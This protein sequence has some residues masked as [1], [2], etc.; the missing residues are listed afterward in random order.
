MAGKVEVTMAPTSFVVAAGDTAEA[1][2]T[3][4]NQG[5]TVDQLTISIDGLDPGWYSIPV[6][7]VALFPNDQDKLKILI[8]PPKKA[9]TKAGSYPFRVNV[10]SQENPAEI[11]TVDLL[12][13]IRALPEMEVSI[14]PQRVVGHKGIYKVAINNKSSSDA[15]VRLRA[16]DV[17]GK[18]RYNLEPE[19]FTVPGSGHSEAT[20]E[21]RLGWLDFFG[22]SKE[23]DF[24]VL[25]A[26]PEGQFA[27]DTKVITGQLVRKT[28][29]RSFPSI[30]L[31]RIRLRW[32]ERPPV[33]NTF[34]AS[35]EDKRE[36]MLDWVVKRATEVKLDDEVVSPEGE[37]LVRPAEPTSYVLVAANKYGSVSRTVELKPAPLPVAKTSERIRASLMPAH[38]QTYAGGTPV[39]A[40]LQLQNLGEIVDKFMV[41]VEGLDESWYSRSAS[42][43]ALMPQATDQVQILLNPPKKKGV[44]SKTYPF[45][46]TVRSQSAPE[47]A[48]TVVAEL[49]V[50]PSVEFK[51]GVHP[52][53][54][55]CRR[56][57]TFQVTLA[58]TGV[59]DASLYLDSTDLDEGLKFRFKND[60]PEVISWKTIETPMVARPKRGSMVGEKKRYDITIRATTAD[61]N[62]QSVNAEL[63]HNPFIGSWR[64]ILRVIRAVLVI[65]VI[66]VL[67]YFVLQWG[68]GWRTLT[69][70]PQTW[71]NQLVNTVEGW[72]FR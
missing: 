32:L 23:F 42:S 51:L 46:V 36:F 18:L 66:G 6:S 68:G 35:M 44:K 11:T 8:H 27:E 50:Q 69:S 9:E 39:E 10:T 49:E 56:K 13:E 59:S 37:R 61:G 47:E 65:A 28:W 64:P 24:E 2:A 15:L 33:I 60:N 71:V 43:M 38:F 3:L 63:Y 12:V 40:T 19:I 1:T 48:T 55:S 22:G 52:Y 29:Y 26:S 34:K 17:Q 4:H 7:S 45:A 57:G 62:T 5:Q 53:R 72:F 16:S 67:I 25:V 70:S 21:V 20:L 41:E 54:V 14:S 30:R 31:P 58:N